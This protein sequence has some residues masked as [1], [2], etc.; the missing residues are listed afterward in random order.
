M[1]NIQDI[2]KEYSK[3]QQTFKRR[4]L[5][6]YFQYKILNLVYQSKYSNRLI[7][8]GG[9]ALKIIYGNPRFS[10]DLDFDNLGISRNDFNLLTS[11]I[12]KGLEKEGYKIEVRNIFKGAFRCYL[13]ILEI[14]FEFKL[15][16]HESEKVLIQLDT[17]PHKF[18][19]MPKD[20]LIQKFEVYRW[21]KVVPIDII[22]AQKIATI[23]ERKR[24]K[25]RDF[26]DIVFLYSKTKPNY[27]Y[28]DSKLGIKNK[29]QL[30]KT[31][32]KTARELDFRAL[33]K[34]VEPFLFDP[35]QKDR[36]LYFEKFIKQL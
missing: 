9:T 12:K 21:I 26:F 11:S 7:F 17:A 19:Y 4:I 25:G 27:Q 20:H 18:S 14:L 10:E 29:D 24:T 22:L 16:T 23:L 8:L 30:K 6:E 31:L 33:A 32:I 5:R 2:I 15:T 36:V 28:L 13:K 3:P 35:S 34:D 1:I